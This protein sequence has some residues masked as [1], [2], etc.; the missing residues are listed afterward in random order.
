ME[1]VCTDR[2]AQAETDFTAVVRRRSGVGTTLVRALPGLPGCVHLEIVLG[3]DHTNDPFRRCRGAPARL[4][5]EVRFTKRVVP[6]A[7]SV[8]Q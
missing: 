5:V 7:G 2:F 1:R 4:D 3:R 8:P 6:S